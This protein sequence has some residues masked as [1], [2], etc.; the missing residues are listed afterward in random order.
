[1]INPYA[2]FDCLSIGKRLQAI[3]NNFAEAEV[4][5]FSYLSCLLLLYRQ[6]PIADWK[7][8]YAGTKNGAPFSIEVS[9]ALKRLQIMGFIEPNDDYLRVTNRGLEEYERLLS[10]T[11]NSQ[12]E[13]FLEGACSSVLSLPVGVIRNAISNDPEIKR[14]SMSAAR[15]LLNDNRVDA[16][17]Q[18]FSALS[19]A[20][21]IQVK[22][23]MVPAVVWLTY[24]TRTS[25]QQSLYI[26]HHQ[27]EPQPRSY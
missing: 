8:M 15:W 11:Q 20:I 4:H 5:L 13:I 26:E 7:Y 9:A 27:H 10:L 21:G 22:D 25:S 14:A 19:E 3:L 24:L 2:L 12:R 18:E 23:L 1:M 16:L 17:Y 6:K